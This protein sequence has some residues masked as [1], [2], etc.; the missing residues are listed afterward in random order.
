MTT[1]LRIAR[2]DLDAIASNIESL[3]GRVGTEHA[4]IVVKADGYGH[5]AIAAARAGLAGGADWIGV[6]DIGEALE[7]RSA[8]ITAP[9]LAWLHSSS[10]TFT[11]AAEA[12]VDVGVSS[13]AQL[14]RAVRAGVSSVH[15]KIDTG[16]ARN[17]AAPAQWPEFFAHAARVGVGK[18]RVRGLFSHIA[19]AGAEADAA[20]VAAFE[21]AIALAESL[22]LE[23][24]LR[25]LAASASSLRVPSARFDM[26]RFGLASYGL[27]PFAD[28]TGA[29]LGLTPALELSSEVVATRRVPADTG[30]SYGYRYRTPRETTLALVP[31]GYEDG[32][33]RAASLGAHVLVGDELAP[34]AGSIAMDQLVVDVGDRPVAVGDRVVAFGDPAT[35]AP[36]MDSWADAAGT[37]N[38]EVTTR[39]GRRVVRHYTGG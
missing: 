32:L 31:L 35:G 25:H 10:E 33:P 24:E 23:F 12:G 15:L 22:G 18:T 7:L 17:G 3:R 21:G 1:P 19:N 2:I 13:T 26:V 16:L 36:T 11:D 28:E 37:I 27:S 14:D 38:Y 30:V 8:G 34:V 5:G 29:E 4:M 39:L 6:A 9:V 20:Q